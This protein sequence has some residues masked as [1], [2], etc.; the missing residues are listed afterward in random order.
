MT[1]W[2]ALTTIAT[3]TLPWR[4]RITIT[5]GHH[6]DDPDTDTTTVGLGFTQ[7]AAYDPDQ[8]DLT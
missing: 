2:T 5:L 6:P 4:L 1:G 7:P 3:R 8:E